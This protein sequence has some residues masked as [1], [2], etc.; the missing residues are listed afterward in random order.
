MAL[1]RMG[2]LETGRE[3][4]L[5][6]RSLTRRPAWEI[7]GAEQGPPNPG[8]LATFLQGECWDVSS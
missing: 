5:T 2:A 7:R 8:L 4:L 3:P 6:H 1:Q